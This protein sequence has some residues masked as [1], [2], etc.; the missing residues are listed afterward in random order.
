MMFPLKTPRTWGSWGIFQQ[1]MFDHTSA[2]GS[3]IMGWAYGSLDHGAHTHG[4]PHDHSLEMV[5][6]SRKFH[7]KK[8]LVRLN[9]ISNIC[10]PTQVALPWSSWLWNIRGQKRDK[11]LNIPCYLRWIHWK[12]AKY[13]PVCIFKC[14][15]WTDFWVIPA[16]GYL[17]HCYLPWLMSSRIS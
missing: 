6:T 9:A 2:G 4:R 8:T 14:G 10:P 3:S 11:H 17:E 7:E 1:A 16:N 13:S 12:L 5:G 15:T